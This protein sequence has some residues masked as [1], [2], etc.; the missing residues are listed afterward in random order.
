M[1]RVWA[2]AA[3]ASLLALVCACGT[4]SRESDAARPVDAEPDALLIPLELGTG[5]VGFESLSAT[6]PTLEIVYGPQGGYHV[7]LSMRVRGIVPAEMLYRLVREDDGHVLANLDL[8]V[9]AGTFTPAGEALQRVGDLVV[10]NVVSPA[11]V[12][13]RDVRVEAR[14]TSSTGERVMASRTLRIVDAEP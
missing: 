9:R 1:K 11:D 6:S 2:N 4:P 5:E 13:M 14:V 12:L 3:R 10:L 7:F 8:L